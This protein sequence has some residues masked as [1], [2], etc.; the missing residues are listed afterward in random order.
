M[1]KY[2]LTLKHFVDEELEGEVEVSFVASTM[3]TSVDYYKVAAI[4]KLC[5][6]LVNYVKEEDSYV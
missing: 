6:Q 1:E 4:Q 5:D 3:Y 2:T